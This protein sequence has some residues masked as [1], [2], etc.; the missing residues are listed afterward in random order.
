MAQE[1]P[2]PQTDVD[3][4][5][6]GAVLAEISRSLVA[7][8]KRNYG[9]GPVRARSFLQKDVLTVILEGGYTTIEQK[10]EQHGHTNEVI[11]TRLAMQKAVEDEMRTAIETILHRSVRSFMSANDPANDLQA[12]VFVLDPVDVVV[13]DEHPVVA[14]G[15]EPQSFA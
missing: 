14:L 12:E 2:R 3:N 6:L 8:F 10:L 4:A 11:A 9:K 15:G 5:A 7:V 1:A 13:D